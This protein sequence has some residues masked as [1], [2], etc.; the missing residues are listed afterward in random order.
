MFRYE[1]NKPYHKGKTHWQTGT[2]FNWRSNTL[3]LRLFF[4]KLTHSDIRAIRNG[5]CEFALTVIDGVIFFLFNFGQ[6]CPWSDNSYAWGLI[7]EGE[8]TI[9]PELGPG[10]M[11][12]LSIILVSAEDGIIRALRQISL[13][14]NFSVKLFDAIRAQAQQPFDAARHTR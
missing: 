4:D 1:V 13:G 14:H 3:E 5:P 2:D 12:L 11:A 10:E 6:A 7:A 9:P 8:R